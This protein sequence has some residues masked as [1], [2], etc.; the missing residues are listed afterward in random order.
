MVAP[1]S[2]NRLFWVGIWATVAVSLVLTAAISVF[3]ITAIRNKPS[4]Q[5]SAMYKARCHAA[6][7]QGEYP[8]YSI[9]KAKPDGCQIML[10]QGGQPVNV[11]W[12]EGF[13]NKIISY[14]TY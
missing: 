4:M 10:P 8:A 5:E 9:L 13:F 11:E 7:S 3:G 6:V 1:R 12:G 2:S 14:R